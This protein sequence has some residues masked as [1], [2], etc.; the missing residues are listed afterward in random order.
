M[1]Y[2]V[3]FVVLTATTTGS[4]QSIALSVGNLPAGLAASLSPATI[5]SGSTSALTISASPTAPAGTYPLTVTATGTAATHTY[6]IS[7][8][9]TAAST[10]T[11]LV[12]V[13][14]SGVGQVTSQDGLLN[15]I[16]T[17]CSAIYAVGSSISLSEVPG[18]NYS[19]SNWGEACSGQGVCTFNV[20]NNML[21]TATFSPIPGTIESALTTTVVGSGTISSTDG[22]VNCS[23]SCV[24]VYPNTASVI[25]S[26]VPNPG[27]AFS[28]WS[29]DCIGQGRCLLPLDH[30]KTVQATFSA[31]AGSTTMVVSPGTITTVAGNG[32]QGSGGDGGPAS[33]ATLNAPLGTAEDSQGNVYIADFDGDRIRVVNTQSDPIT[34][35]GVTIQ[36][37]N[38]ATI[39]GDGNGKFSGD[40]GPAT[41]AE[42]YGPTGLH[43]DSSGNL[44]FAD[45][46]NNRVRVINL[47]ASPIMVAGITIQPGTIMTVAGNGVY[48]YTGDGGP[49]TSAGLTNPQ[50]VLIDGSGNIYIAEF[51]RVRLV[52]ALTGIISTFAGGGSQ[53]CASELVPVGCPANQ[54]LE[55]SPTALAM[56]SLGNLFLSDSGYQE[57]R[58]VYKAGTFTGLPSNPVSG[59]V[60]VVAG[61][62]SGCGE[63]S[64]ISGDGCPVNDAGQIVGL[65]LSVD[66]A[67]SLYFANLNDSRIHRVDRSSGLM[68][69]LAGN[70]TA[71]YLQDGVPATSTEISFNPFWYGNILSMDS[72]G[73]LYF[74]DANTNRVRQ[75][76]LAGAPLA[77]LSPAVGATGAGVTIMVENIGSFAMNQPM[78]SISGANQT[79]FSETDTCGSSIQ[80]GSNCTIT[81][82]FTPGAPG[83]RYAELSVSSGNAG[84]SPQTIE[85]TG[86][87]VGAAGTLSLSATS[88]PF[89]TQSLPASSAVQAITITNTGT[90]DLPAPV[91][92]IGGANAS[93]F[94]SANTCQAG[95]KVGASCSVA[96]TF[97]PVAQGAAA[98]LLSIT[99]NSASNSPLQVPLSGYAVQT[100][101]TVLWTP[102]VSSLAYGTPLSSGVLDATASANGS[103]VPGTFSYAA[104]IAGGSPQPITQ[105]TVLA[106]GAYIL[107]TTFSPTDT[108]DY[109]S[110]TASIPF[111]INAGGPPVV[112]SLFPNFGT[113]LMQTFTMQYS[114]PDGTS[115]L[116]QAL[117]VFNTS[118][119]L[120]S[121]CAVAYTPGTNK[122]HLYNDA[123]TAFLTAI[124]PNSSASVSNSQ[125]TLSGLGSSI[126]VAGNNLTV[127]I[128]LA[129]TGSFVGQKNVYMRALGKTSN[130]GWVKEG[131]W[132]PSMVVSLSPASGVGETQTFTMVYSDPNGTKDLSEVLVLFNSSAQ[133]K[134]GCAVAYTPGTNKLHLYNN[135][136]TALSAGITP[137]SAGSV[138]NSQCTLV[139]TGSSF[140]KSGNN[141]TLNVVL[142]FTSAFVGSKMVYLDA[143]G[144]AQ[145]SGWVLK[146][147]WTP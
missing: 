85:L 115:D 59:Y 138:S 5:T 102:S 101:P 63:Q 18:A 61:Q 114:D 121:A 62:G 100:T 20:I 13:Q 81:V 108:T 36:P 82:V 113:G 140:S 90:A 132:T 123:G 44:Y 87:E 131:T 135:A 118:V 19:F 67:G 60:Y 4:A 86:N 111:T 26:A 91:F 35:A 32:T 7:V 124:A 74:S 16:N 94:S 127:N 34:V 129:F 99:D 75:I 76:N 11:Y 72:V 56:D 128:A 116:S 126:S 77:L 6:Q 10:P 89:G 38:I 52:N 22:L 37:G 93:E 49:A 88:I 21:V 51:L 106:V 41:S 133:L 120:G 69:A 136:G 137:G 143:V 146:G 142:N 117:V 109:T 48:G 134:S 96:V 1:G 23:S 125:C 145:S 9:V 57:I 31:V 144:T 42:I 141:L 98:A 79:E 55:P 84:N 122:L 66:S 8:T 3:N 110:A 70:G 54:G 39:A 139:G 73:N 105:T 107:T 147:N 45:A 12:T 30:N 17:S 80:S 83:T 104:T 130:S 28:A 46:D 97:A 43:F 78:L 15:C 2:S 29:G 103:T 24:T 53:N 50:D 71:G 14:L 33:L 27:Y 58:M 40:G 119:N 65:G 112:L 68:T 92:S 47:Q 95:V 64:D 25:L